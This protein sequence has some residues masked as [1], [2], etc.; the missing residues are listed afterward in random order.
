MWDIGL[1]LNLTKTIFMRNGQVS[2]APF[3]LNGTNISKCSSYVYVDREINATNDLMLGVAQLTQV[4]GLRSS[5]LRRRS[6]NRRCRTG[7]VEQVDDQRD[8][9]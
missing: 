5:K 9:S 6:K 3:S 4:R 7:Q 8:D 2:E 1:Q